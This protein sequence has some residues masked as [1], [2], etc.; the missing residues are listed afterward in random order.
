MSTLKYYD[1]VSSSWVPLVVGSQGPPGQVSGANAPLYYDSGTGKIS[2]AQNELG[3][4]V[5]QVGGAV[6]AIG[7]NTLTGTNIF[8]GVTTFNTTANF[9][10]VVATA[11]SVTSAATSSNDVTNKSYVDSA[12]SAAS[13]G[14]ASVTNTDGTVTVDNTDPKNPIVSLPSVVTTGTYTKVTVDAKGRITA[15][16]ILAT[17]DIPSLDAN[18]ITS[19]TL[20][21][22]N[23][24]TG[25][26][27]APL[28]LT[29]LG[30]VAAASPTFTGTATF[31]GVTLVG[32]I[33]DGGPA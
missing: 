23:G 9:V 8:N 2:I 26:T 14:I 4:S 17:T 12:V 27:T 30:A 16:T 24:G 21:V 29:S 25:A 13:A 28:A 15:G 18:K 3:L 22:A 5:N 10:N 6:S 33:I 11:M 7:S 32:L 20:A 1:T 19:G 31:T